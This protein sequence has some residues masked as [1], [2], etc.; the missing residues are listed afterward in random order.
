MYINILHL[1]CFLALKDLLLKFVVRFGGEV[2][3][4]K[5]SSVAKSHQ[6]TGPR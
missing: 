2:H 5:G 1:L 6:V 4:G 3:L